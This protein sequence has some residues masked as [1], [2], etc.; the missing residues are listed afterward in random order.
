MARRRTPKEQC[1]RAAAL[2]AECGGDIVAAA[3]RAGMNYHTF[4]GHY[5]RSKDYQSKQSDGFVPGEPQEPGQTKWTESSEAAE[6]RAIV[7][8]RITVKSL[9]EL[10]K[11]CDVD[12]ET[13]EV[14]K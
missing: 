1:D 9:P 13:W 5:R 11:A 4:Y 2:V 10:L 12:T 3:D 14:D 6:L 8:E 7:N